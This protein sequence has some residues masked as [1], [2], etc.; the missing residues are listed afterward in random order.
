M[1]IKGDFTGFTFDGVHSSQLGITRVSGGDRY[2]VRLF[3]EMNDMTGEVPGLDGNYFFGSNFGTN[4]MTL[5]I[6]Y[7]SMTE[8]Q[9]RRIRQLFST[10]KICSLVFDETPY[11]RYLVKAASPIELNY[12]CFDEPLKI[13]QEYGTGVRRI[14]NEQG[15]RIWEPTVKDV[16]NNSKT[17]RAYKGEGTIELIGYYPFAK[18]VFKVLPD[19]SGVE[20]KDKQYPNISEWAESSRL[21]TAEQY[22]EYDSFETVTV[23]EETKQVCKLYNPGDVSTGL[24]LYCPFTSISEGYGSNSLEITYLPT[25]V[26]IEKDANIIKID[27]ITAANSEDIG[28]LINTDIGLIYGVTS[29]SKDGYDVSYELS[30]RIYNEYFSAG[31]FFRIQPSVKYD[32]EEK[33][34]IDD[35]KLE[36]IGGNDGMEVFYDYLYM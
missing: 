35:A 6:A 13:G 34:V 21:L 7:D 16:Y 11:K 18:S 27:A 29:F 10:K 12:V 15:K 36:V 4:T 32:S 2:E 8:I 14:K 22:Q 20:E 1:G 17:Q 19:E 5:Q 9:L 30:D 25:G 23:D 3:A 33:P 31:H 24:R 26:P 28:M